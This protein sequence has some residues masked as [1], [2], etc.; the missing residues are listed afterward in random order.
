MAAGE[1]AS[2]GPRRPRYEPVFKLAS[3]GMATVH[4]GYLRGAL[5]FRQI[6]AIKQPHP[7]LLEDPA[8]RKSFVAEAM[9]ASKI[10][11]ANVVDVRD[12]E[13][14]GDSIVLVMDYV[15]GASL[16]IL[17]HAVAMSLRPMPVHVAVRIVMDACAGLH[18]AHEAT[19]ELGEPLGIVH[20]DVSPQNILVGVDGV[21]RL[22]DF[23]IAKCGMAVATPT[24]QQGTLKGKV[25]YM[26]PEYLLNNK[27]D[28][29]ADVFGLGVVL[30][31]VLCGRPLFAGE[32]EADT[33]LRVLNEPIPPLCGM[34]PEAI[35]ALQPVVDQALCRDPE[36]R[37]SSALAMAT[38]LEHAS[39]VCGLPSD[40]RRVGDFVQQCVGAELEQRRTRLREALEA[41]SSVLPASSSGSAAPASESADDSSSNASSL[42]SGYD[43]HATPRTPR[44]SLERRPG[45]AF[46]GAMVLL[47]A[48]VAIAS[49]VLVV[50]LVAPSDTA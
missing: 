1:A 15:E 12:V 20:R 18:A 37:F 34:T 39:Q 41:R 48:S 11:H 44:A 7:H 6:V 38:A 22:V 10:H 3:G 21:A 2:S 14:S 26:A 31:E 32:N 47:L 29:R 19:S 35:A 16:S 40:H 42:H 36:H 9:L 23:G 45:P 28:R 5:G 33:L 43:A 30:W 4:I 49:A 50:R 17:E 24:T 25:G 27:I 13:V 8:F 46:W